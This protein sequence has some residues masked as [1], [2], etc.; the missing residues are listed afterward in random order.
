MLKLALGNQTFTWISFPIVEILLQ[1]ASFKPQRKIY[2][3]EFQLVIDWQLRPCVLLVSKK[4]KSP[5]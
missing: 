5:N 4:N 2:L 1:R 3:K